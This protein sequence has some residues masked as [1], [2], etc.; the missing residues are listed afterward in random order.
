MLKK[1]K[2]KFIHIS[3]KE[4][5]K[6]LFS[7]SKGYRLKIL[8]LTLLR[9]INSLATIGIALLTKDIID[10]AINHELSTAYTLG[11]IIIIGLILK[12]ILSKYTSV[13]ST[14]VGEIM[15]NELQYKVIQSF[16]NNQ[17]LFMSQFKTG[18]LI[19]RATN[20]VSKVKRIFLSTF[21]SIVSL[22]TQLITAFII[23]SSYDRLIAFIAFILGPTTV[24]IS[25]ILGHKLKALQYE[26]QDSISELKSYITESIQNIDL[27]QSFDIK[28][29]SLNKLNQ[30]Q[31]LKRKLVFKKA[32]FSAIAKGL[33][34]FGFTI[35]FLGAILLGAYKLYKGEISFGTFT[36]FSQLVTHI[37]SPI[38]GLSKKLPSILTVLSSVERIV[39][40]DS[41]DKAT[42]NSTDSIIDKDLL[43]LNFKNVSFAYKEDFNIIDDINLSINTGEKIA[44]VGTSGEGKTTILRLIMALLE[45]TQGQIILSSKSKIMP[46]SS[47]TR[48]YFS[49]VPQK[50][51]LF[52]GTIQ[53]NLLLANNNAE[54]ITLINALKTACIFDYISTL[55]DGINTIIGERLGGL[56]E[57]QAQRICIARALIHNTPFLILDE[58][59]SALDIET[60]KNIIANISKYYADKTL[61]VVTHKTEILN[62]CDQVYQLNSKKITKVN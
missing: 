58:A 19:T 34:D 23:L 49:Y 57:G 55:P 53:E 5:L 45:P 10:S 1:I 2:E 18:D 39:V 51:S 4:L 52:F 15:H 38:Y 6:H 36:A 22:L 46:I 54:Y 31:I 16:Y 8:F 42:S 35:G 60:E 37:Q 48:K 29:A 12:L 26:I 21:P 50:N 59:T 32:I 47:E 30:Y 13:Y 17:W 40:F 24:S 11:A 43:N 41:L 44:L 33:I 28:E 25:W 56:S 7:Y 3:N 61:I 27:I 9:A 20:D 14:K 62:Y